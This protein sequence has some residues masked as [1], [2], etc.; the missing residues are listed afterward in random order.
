M[1]SAWGAIW[2]GRTSGQPHLGLP[3]P[4]DAEAGG[5]PV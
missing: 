5:S 3:R 1:I 4:G 2:A